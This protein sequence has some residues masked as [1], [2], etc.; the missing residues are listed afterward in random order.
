MVINSI[1]YN[2]DD[3]ARQITTFKTALGS[4]ALGSIRYNLKMSVICMV[5]C[6]KNINITFFNCSLLTLTLC[7]KCCG[8]SDFRHAF[9]LII[10]FA[11]KMG[12]PV[13]IEPGLSVVW[14][15]H[16]KSLAA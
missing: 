1:D 14:R 9:I 5:I 2:V 16:K 13:D 4:L 6:S 11:R 3:H 7:N 12:C 8:K 15:M 10:I